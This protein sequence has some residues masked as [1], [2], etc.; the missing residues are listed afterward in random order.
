M[1]GLGAQLLKVQDNIPICA[2][3]IGQRLALHSLEE[4]LEWIKVRVKDLEKNRNLL[5]KV[6]LPLGED[7][8]KG[9]EGAIYLWAKL[10][11]KY[12]DDFEVV[13]WLVRRHGVVVIPGCAS[14][15]PGYI[16]ISFGGLKEADCETAAA[17]LKRGLE[18][19]VRDGMV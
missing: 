16:R 18:E 11:E 8:V 9:G 13:R 15:G 17:R 5:R 7:A 14:G 2:S 12:S 1:E 6:L 10:P 19:L 3:I 4:G